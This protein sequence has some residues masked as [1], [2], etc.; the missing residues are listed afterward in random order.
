[1]AGPRWTSTPTPVPAQLVIKGDIPAQVQQDIVSFSEYV[2]SRGAFARSTGSSLVLKEVEL[3]R[4][5]KDGKNQARVV[6]E[7]TV[8][9]EMLNIGGNMHGGCAVYLI[10]VCSSMALAVLGM[11]TDKPWNFVSQA[12]TTTF[13]APAPAGVKIEIINTTLSFGSRTVSAITEIWDVTNNRLCVTG[14]HNKMKPSEP[15]A[16]L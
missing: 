5:D 2:M 13:H 9:E 6:Y 11:A 15:K 1:M 14:T 16:K 4:R 10:D 3:F 8:H 12:I 7:T